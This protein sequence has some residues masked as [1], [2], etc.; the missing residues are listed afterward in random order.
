MKP[1]LLGVTLH[2]VLISITNEENEGLSYYIVCVCLCVCEEQREKHL[3]PDYFCFFAIQCTQ[4]GF[5]EY[6][7]ARQLAAKT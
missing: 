5:I 6:L 4:F 3:S 7:R 2:T 1:L